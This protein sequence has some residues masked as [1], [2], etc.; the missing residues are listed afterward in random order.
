MKAS[1]TSIPTQSYH[2]IFILIF[3]RIYLIRRK[4]KVI[5]NIYFQ[6]IYNLLK[7]LETYPRKKK[8]RKAQDRFQRYKNFPEDEKQKLVE[9]R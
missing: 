5:L 6:C 1:N 3:V 8:K 9:Y 7:T 4:L 2:L